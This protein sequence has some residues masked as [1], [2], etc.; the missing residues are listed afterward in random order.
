M[1]LARGL[2]IVVLSL[3][4]V[5]GLSTLTHAEGAA[6]AVYTMNNSSNGNRVLVF[7]RAADGTLTAAG[8]FETGG[9]GT[10]GGLGNQGALVLDSSERWLFAVNAGSDEISV[11]EV[12][13]RGLSLVDRVPS[14]GR[15]PISL[16][17]HDDLLYVL[18]AG[19]AAGDSD[20]ITGF[21]LDDDGHLAPI[22]GS[23]R[24]LSAAST[25]PAQ[26][27]FESEGRVLV[28]T[29][30]ATSRID[31]YTVDEVGLA[32]GLATFPSPGQTP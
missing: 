28:V 9:L 4:V 6:G 1:K 7:A 19:G 23:T 10:G 24:P 20:N 32:T 3:A 13:P 5:S 17:V 2:S 25:G 14:D 26:I 21:R 11:F 8:S 31:T 30:K 29:E 18:N 22:A 12:E 27:Q 16:T 15:R